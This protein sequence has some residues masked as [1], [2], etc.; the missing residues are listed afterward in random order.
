MATGAEIKQQAM[1]TTEY[2]GK[3]VGQTKTVG[4]GSDDFAHLPDYSR[5]MDQL[6]LCRIGLPGSADMSGALVTPNGF[7]QWF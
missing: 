1:A 5:W 6:E 2:P 4:N 7:C 3:A